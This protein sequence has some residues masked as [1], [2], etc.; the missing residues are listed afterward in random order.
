MCQSGVCYNNGTSDLG[1]CTTPPKSLHLPLKCESSND[2]IGMN[3]MNQ[4]FQGQCICGYNN[5]GDSYC[6]A[7][8]G[9]GPGKL[10]I[11]V[12][13][14]LLKAGAMAGCQTARRHYSDCLDMVA[15][16]LGQNANI[17][18]SAFMNFTNYPAYID[19]DNCVKS[20]ITN[21]F[22][23]HLPPGPPG[24]NPHDHDDHS[25]AGILTV[26]FGLLWAL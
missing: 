13:S 24:P 15:A 1:V 21:E 5:N 22:W 6:S 19:N 10:Y 8:A 16:K 17:W 3:S 11:D 9:D 2:C 20:I 26:F 12:M 4:T 18:Y 25:A 7:H 14:V 23:S